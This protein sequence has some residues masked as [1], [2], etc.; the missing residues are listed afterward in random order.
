MLNEN[1]LYRVRKNWNK[2]KWDNTQ[3]GAYRNLF[4]A[5]HVCEER[6]SDGYKVFDEKGI[7]IY[8]IEYENITNTLITSDIVKAD[9][10]LLL[11]Y[12][13]NCAKDKSDVPF[14]IVE[15]IVNRCSIK[16]MD[17]NTKTMS[18]EIKQYNG[19]TMYKI[20]PKYFKIVYVDKPKTTL[21][22]SNY[23]NLG[24]FG[25]YKEDGT[26]FTLPVANLVADIN[27]NDVSPVALKYLKERKV[28]NGKLYFYCNKNTTDQFRNKDVS[29]LIVM[30][31]NTVQIDQY[32]SLYD[33]D[34]KYA[35]S[36]CP[37]IINGKQATSDQ[38]KNEG[39]DDSIT[40]PTCHGCLGIK[41][42][43]I[44]YFGIDT[45]SRNCIKY[46][47]I[48]EKIYDFGFTD[49]IKVD[50]GGSYY[51]KIDGVTDSTIGDRKINNIGVIID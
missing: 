44:Y 8:P 41:D 26:T 36:G 12:I 48:Y 14:E 19:I 42:G 13:N 46:G 39:W 28:E 2:G 50:G 51:Y 4:E 20:N 15:E 31:D 33:N 45:I 40:R 10:Y 47:E 22:Y 21:T 5:L 16:V 1:M 18:Y 23:F 34:V 29:T 38:C 49:L 3:L 17:T 32:N 43:Y 7:V 11:A 37:I 24:Y 30:N 9:S 6:V 27:E 35:V 25:N